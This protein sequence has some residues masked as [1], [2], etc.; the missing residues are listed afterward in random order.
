MNIIISYFSNLLLFAERVGK[1]PIAVIGSQKRKNG[2]SVDLLFYEKD[3]NKILSNIRKEMGQG[4]TGEIKNGITLLEPKFAPHWIKISKHL[5]LWEKYYRNNKLAFQNII[6]DIKKLSGTKNFTLSKTDIYFVSD[7]LS[8]YNDINAWFSWTPKESFM[9]VEISPNFNVSKDYFPIGI[10]AHEFFHLILRADKRLMLQIDKISKK[11]TGLLSRL[12]KGLIPNRMFL[13]ELLVSSFIP[14][15]YLS[16]KYL[17]IKT[18][19]NNPSKPGNLLAWR[20]LVASQMRDTVKKYM[21]D[22]KKIDERY[23]KLLV[24]VIKQNVN[25]TPLKT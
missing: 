14:E 11:N 17:H 4:K 7:P 19:S 3:K 18:T 22:D 24:E 10:L 8:K 15:G 5:H 9:V 2:G 20:R 12:S 23:L 13:E 21:D 1:N 6:S 16:E 25:K